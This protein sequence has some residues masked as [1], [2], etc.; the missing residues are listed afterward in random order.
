MA[1]FELVS[2][3]NEKVTIDADMAS[4]IKFLEHIPEPGSEIKLSSLEIDAN[5][6]KKIKTFLE[7]KGEFPV[8]KGPL[9]A[10][11]TESIFDS[12]SPYRT[13]F[14]DINEDELLLLTL[15]AHKLSIENLQELCTAVIAS[16]F[17]EMDANEVIN[18]LTE[19]ELVNNEEDYLKWTQFNWH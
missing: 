3:E 12:A 18:D 19:A 1:S 17:A 8:I 6:L 13:F 7:V 16:K 14:Q 15:A 2:W 4:A 10:T 11:R 9:Q 5:T